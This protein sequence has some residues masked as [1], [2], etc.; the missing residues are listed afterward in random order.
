MSPAETKTHCQVG[1]SASLD[2]PAGG[3]KQQ[4]LMK[5][6]AVQNEPTQFSKVEKII[7]TKSDVGIVRIGHVVEEETIINL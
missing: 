6:A 7:T 5:S 3:M 1:S 2:L 4:P